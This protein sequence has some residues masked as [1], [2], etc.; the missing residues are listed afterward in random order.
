M[1]E[2]WQDGEVPGWWCVHGNVFCSKEGDDK[3]EVSCLWGQYQLRVKDPDPSHIVFD[4][5]NWQVRCVMG[6]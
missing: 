5:W 1:Q 3:E 4:N 6:G 2:V